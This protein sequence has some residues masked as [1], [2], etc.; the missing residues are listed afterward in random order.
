MSANDIPLNSPPPFA[1]DEWYETV[2][3]RTI[4]IKEVDTI[5]DKIYN[6]QYLCFNGE[7]ASP[8]KKFDSPQQASD[9]IKQKALEFGADI[10]GICEIEPS[11]VYKGKTVI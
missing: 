10:V 8:K 5:L 1:W 4:T 11:D 2:G 3:G 9:L 7:V 6:D